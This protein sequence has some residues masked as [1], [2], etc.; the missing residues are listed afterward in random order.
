[1][2]SSEQ[3][4]FNKKK[5]GAEKIDA[6]LKRGSR[7]LSGKLCWKAIGRHEKKEGTEEKLRVG[8]LQ[9]RHRHQRRAN[10]KEKKQ[11]YTSSRASFGHWERV[12]KTKQ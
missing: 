6:L 5:E 8:Y 9:G 7:E 3:R 2:I 1:M 12:F 11:T 4:K 10:E